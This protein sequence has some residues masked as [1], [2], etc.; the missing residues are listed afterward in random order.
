[1]ERGGISRNSFGQLYG[2]YTKKVKNKVQY[3]VIQST[4]WCK[5]PLHKYVT[6][7]GGWV[8]SK[9]DGVGWAGRDVT[10]TI[11]LEYEFYNRCYQTNQSCICCWQKVTTALPIITKN[12]TVKDVVEVLDK[13]LDL[14]QFYLQN[15]VV[16]LSSQI[17]KLPG[18]LSGFLII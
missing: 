15:N 3:S 8:P 6:L 9:R 16:I 4:K 17:H 12:L 5:G 11:N 18:P 7:E 2:I 13:C 10:P 1:M 14:F